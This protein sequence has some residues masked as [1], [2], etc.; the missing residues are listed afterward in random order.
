M[1]Y[2]PVRGTTAR[3]TLKQG[4]KPTL[5]MFLAQRPPRRCAAILIITETADK[6]KGVI[7]MSSPQRKTKQGYEEWLNEMSSTVDEGAWVMGGVVRIYH[8][9]RGQY[10]TALRK[11]DPIAFEVGYRY[12]KP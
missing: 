10:G 4:E 5:P 6:L 1:K 11:Y 3:A 8:K 7:S 2:S 9:S 12:W